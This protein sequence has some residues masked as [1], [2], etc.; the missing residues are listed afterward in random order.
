MLVCI[1]IDIFEV[2][3]L[4]FLRRVYPDG[5]SFMQDNDPKHHRSLQGSSLLRT[6]SIG[7]RLRLRALMPIILKIFGTN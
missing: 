2:G 5:H 1:Y 7:G 4:P 3:L 6:A